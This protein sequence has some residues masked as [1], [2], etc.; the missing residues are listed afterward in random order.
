MTGVIGLI[1]LVLAPEHPSKADCEESMIAGRIRLAPL[2][3]QE[4]PLDQETADTRTR[5]KRC[6]HTEQR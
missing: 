3:L 5:S 6:V 1:A 2:H 4:L